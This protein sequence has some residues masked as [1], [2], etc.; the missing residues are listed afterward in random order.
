ME[1]CGEIVHGL[2]SGSIP[3]AS[4]LVEIVHDLADPEAGLIQ[5]LSM[6][7]VVAD[8]APSPAAP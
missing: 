4:L 7:L 3:A 8:A 2:I 5:S 6:G 1:I